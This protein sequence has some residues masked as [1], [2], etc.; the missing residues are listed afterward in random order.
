M[1]SVKPFDFIV[2]IFTLATFPHMAGRSRAQNVGQD[3]KIELEQQ[4]KSDVC[5]IY[6]CVDANCQAWRQGDFLVR[7]RTT[8]D[9]TEISADR[10]VKGLMTDNEIF[11]RVIF[12]LDNRKYLYASWN[13]GSAIDFTSH[14]INPE[15]HRQ[16]FSVIGGISSNGPKG[17]VLQYRLSRVPRR[18][19]R[20]YFP[21]DEDKFLIAINFPD[22][23]GFW[24]Y[25]KPTEFGKMEAE[26]TV[27]A[28]K[29]GRF[30]HSSST[31]SQFTKIVYDCPIGDQPDTVLGYFQTWTFE[32]ESMMPVAVVGEGKFK[33][34]SISPGP[35][36]KLSWELLNE[37]YVLHSSRKRFFDVVDTT[38]KREKGT[39]IEDLDF[40]W[41]SLNEELDA[42]LFEAEQFQSEQ[43]L[44]KLVDPRLAGANQLIE[45]SPDAPK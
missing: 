22:Y 44:L 18:T 43:S 34:G 7:A 1:V 13:T 27:E 12:D 10:S 11:T 35:N 15:A 28:L 17:T 36:F 2:L 21:D 5:S 19:N 31:D 6:G 25:Q 33:D 16:L 45:P 30:F 14:P 29:V 40:H 9:S 24:Q 37:V 39:R 8:F 26:S 38:S 23:R 41:F 20:S 4:E 42:S 32:N 3:K